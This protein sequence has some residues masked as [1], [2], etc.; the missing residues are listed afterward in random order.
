ML[1]FVYLFDWFCLFIY[2]FIFGSWFLRLMDIIMQNHFQGNYLPLLKIFI[3]FQNQTEPT[4]KLKSPTASL[5][6]IFGWLL[7]S[8]Q[9]LL[10]LLIFARCIW[11]C[12]PHLPLL[13][14]FRDD[15]KTFKC[16]QLWSPRGSAWCLPA[17]AMISISSLSIKVAYLQ[18]I[19]QPHNY[20]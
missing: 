9:H 15:Q 7:R 5:V 3:H 4:D 11:L 18:H 13:S 12:C 8:V 14:S 19:S 1:G 17:R 20:L 10:D 6:A 16:V 2:L